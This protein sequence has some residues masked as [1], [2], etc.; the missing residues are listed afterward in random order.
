MANVESR[1]NEA[2]SDRSSRRQRAPRACLSCRKRKVRCDVATRGQPCTNCS[3]DHAPCEVKR[4]Q[5]RR[6]LDVLITPQGI[7]LTP[8]APP[9]APAP[10]CNTAH[11]SGKSTELQPNPAE[12][13]RP[14]T[15]GDDDQLASFHFRTEDNTA[16]ELFSRMK[17]R[18]QPYKFLNTEATLSCNSGIDTALT[19]DLATD[20]EPG[21]GPFTNWTNYPFICAKIDPDLPDC[22]LN[23]LQQRGCL[24]IPVRGPLNELIREYFLHVHPNLPVINEADFWDTYTN[25]R[26]EPIPLMLFQAMLFAACSFVGHACIKRLGF[27]SLRAA[28]LAF[29]TRAKTLY[30]LEIHSGDVCCAQTALLLTYYVSPRNPNSN[31]YWLTV[32][33]HHAR[34]IHAHRYYELKHYEKAN[35]LKRIWWACVCR[36]RLLSLGLRRPFQ[37]SDH[38]FDFTQSPLTVSDFSDEIHR[39]LV[40]CANTKRVLIQLLYFQ[41]ELCVALTAGLTLLSPLTAAAIVHQDNLVNGIDELAR[42]YDH[43]QG[44]LEYLTDWGTEHDSTV[45]YRNLLLIYY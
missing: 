28:R 9:I 16:H 21:I 30:D 37:I 40:Y 29:Y 23:L 12:R 4:R 13:R 44:Q 25:S 27:K 26:P 24:S 11:V 5:Q 20:I 8:T 33:I 14:E 1:S 22:D 35:L 41:C 36:D 2:T 6:Q 45:L 43:T 39:S 19:S 38:D 32:A 17:P 3:L 34:V 15:S 18:P 10:R 42:W 31:S 7:P